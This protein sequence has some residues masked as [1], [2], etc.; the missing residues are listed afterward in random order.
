M[1]LKKFQCEN[2]KYSDEKKSL[3]DGGG[4]TLKVSKSKNEKLWVYQYTFNNHR[5]NIPIGNYN[6][7]GLAEARRIRDSLKEMVAAGKDPKVEKQKQ[8]FKKQSTELV[9]FSQA[10]NDTYNH[11]TTRKGDAWSNGHQKRCRSIYKNYLADTLGRLPLTEIT[12]EMILQVLKGI[13]K[14]APVT[15]QKAKHLISRI[16]R[17][18]TEEMIYKGINPVDSLKGNSLIEP[19]KAKHHESIMVDELGEFLYKTSQHNNQ[20]TKSFLYILT[21]TGLR[22]GSLIN[23]RWGWYDKKRAVLNIP[24]EYMKNRLPF[25]CPLPTQAIKEF[26]IMA[27]MGT[28]MNHLIFPISSNVPR[29]AVQKI[30]KSKATAHGL[31]TTF[32][33][34]T[35]SMGCNMLHIGSQM[36]HS[37]AMPKMK[38]TYSNGYIYLKE[39]TELVQQY[40]DWCETQVKVY[41]N[42]KEII[43]GC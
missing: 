29:I 33:L 10:Y 27:N 16:F 6:Q 3:F 23:A 34:A 7:V 4:L 43:N 42:K 22:I 13:Y 14:D 36:S 12:D 28:E 20:I 26:E 9:T 32:N 38:S 11:Y 17:Y 24:P 18:A 1:A 21:V 8:K 2:F 40:A 15:C 5:T 31:R 37:Y 41:L 35:E 39:R 19:P 25:I 30:T